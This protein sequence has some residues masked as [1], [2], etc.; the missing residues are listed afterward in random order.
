MTI[1]GPQANVNPRPSGG[2]T[3]TPGAAS[4]AV[5]DGSAGN[6]GQI[7]YLD[8][9]N[10]TING[11]EVKSGTAD[12]IRQSNAH[13]GTA[14]R[15]NIIHDGRGDEGAQLAKCTS[16]VMEYN[17][18]YDIASPGDALNFADSSDCAI[19]YN[20]V[21][22]STS[23]NGA[24]YVAWGVSNVT[25]RS[26]HVHD[27]TL[28]TAKWGDPGG[29]MLGTA[30]NAATVAV[31]NNCITGNL[32][33]G[34]TNKATGSLDAENNWWG[35]PDG[36]SGSGPGSG[37][38][39]SANVDYDPWLTMPP[40]DVC[41]PPA[42]N[43]TITFHV[44]TGAAPGTGQPGYRVHVYNPGGGE[45]AWKDTDGNGDAAFL[46]NNGNYE[47]AVEKNG[48]YSARQ[49]FFVLGV[50]KTINHRLSVVAITIGD[51]ENPM[52]VHQGYRVHVYRD[53]GG[54]GGEWGWQD[55][56]A[57]GLV[58]FYM[59]DGDYSYR[60]EKNGAYGAAK[61]FTL[62][63]SNDYSETFKLS[64]L[65][66]TIGDH[67]DPMGVHQGYR[68]HVYRDPGG[69]GGEW[70]WQDSDASGLVTFYMVD[71][72]Y[73]YRVEK[74]GAY[75][76][77]RDF[78]ITYCQNH[79]ETYKLS[80]VTVKVTNK[81]GQPLQGY[82]V[83]IYRSTGG[84]GGEWAWQDSNAQGLTIFWMVDG[85]YSYKV[86]KGCYWS[87]AVDF[88]VTYSN[89][90]ALV[91]KATAIITIK[92]G[93]HYGGGHDGYLVRVFKAGG[94][95]IANAWSAGGGLT[96]FELDAPGNYEYRVEKSGA[97][98]P[99]IALQACS[100]QTIEYKL[101]RVVIKVGDHYGGGHQGYLVRV[102]NAG[103]GEWGNAWSDANGFTT[104]WLIEGN[105]EYRV[106]RSGA[107][108]PKVAF[109]V[110]YCHDY[111]GEAGKDPILEYKLSKV[112]IKVGDHYGGGHQGYLVRV[113]NAGA[114]EW[115]NAWS[116]ANGLTTFYLVEGNYG[117]LVEKN[118]VQSAKNGFTVTYC[119]DQAGDD[120][121]VY[122]L[123]KVTIKVQNGGGNGLPGY[124]VRVYN[125]PGSQWGYQWA[126]ASGLTTF[127]LTE[128][129]YKYKVEK[130]SYSKWGD[131]SPF[132]VAYCT[133]K[134]LTHTVVP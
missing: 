92:V 38:A 120:A 20:E 32:P 45:I 93:D 64:K 126:N 8:A 116:D 112:V 28:N 96:T 71:G 76:A 56:D 54:A 107:V 100:S 103:A 25:I 26:N 83:H 98:S 91:H 121:L 52:G 80:K 65:T 2:T 21:Y 55:S 29:I 63:Y 85:S 108:G 130:N 62:T 27:N 33:N 75:G 90:L 47:Y 68:V 128:G 118:G 74:N 86:E 88:T 106:E 99:K 41:P 34:V 60:V 48:A 110:V 127:Y 72:D 123:S 12:M 113:F 31:H 3:R 43:A 119:Q 18:V 36:P 101:S 57:S 131:D 15:Y 114:G 13:S 133:D 61:D 9:N 39:V 46:L 1:L 73:S 87:G 124:L 81:A 109:A 134:Q 44:H 125:D 69:A 58:T 84:G 51:H 37:D 115:G 49:A 5:V 4:E 132:T 67:E 97:A 40:S 30:V 6:L 19:R 122:K 94:G 7:F 77:A 66:I 105:Y 10:I 102:F 42:P 82:R 14:V 53:P 111:D 79:S 104:F 129:R 23:E 95:E 89:D 70:G 78:T 16:C 17:Y 22:N 117:Y 59:V 50:N 35:A 11:L 24:I